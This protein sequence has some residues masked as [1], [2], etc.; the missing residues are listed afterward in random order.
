M[1]LAP[2]LFHLRR[3][4]RP[5][6]GERNALFDDRKLQPPLL[7]KDAIQNHLD[8]VSGTE[9]A[10]R[11]FA[12]DFVCVFAP[13]VAIVA[14]RID[15]HQSLDEEIGQFDKEP[16]FRG[17]Q[18]QAGKFLAD[19]VLHEADFLPLH[20]FALSFGGAALGEAGFLRNL[21]QLRLGNRR[22]LRER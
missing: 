16:V 20:Q 17:V 21:G 15:R 5:S 22:A 13:S 7:G 1:L 3:F 6:S 14:Q 9:A 4:S 11:T 19:A 12:D 10:A 8:P 2:G 18:H